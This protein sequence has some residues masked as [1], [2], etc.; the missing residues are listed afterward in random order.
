MCGSS[1]FIY[2]SGPVHIFKRPRCPRPRRYWTRLEFFTPGISNAICAM[3]ALV[4]VIVLLLASHVNSSPIINFS[5]DTPRHFCGSQ[6]ANVLA[7]ICSH[8]YNFHPVNDDVTPPSRRRKR[9][10]IVEECCENTCTPHHLKAYCW[11][12]QRADKSAFGTSLEKPSVEIFSIP[13][14]PP[15]RQ[16]Q[17]VDNSLLVDQTT[18]KT[19]SNS[20]I[21]NS[22]ENNRKTNNKHNSTPHPPLYI[23][24]LQANHDISQDRPYVQCNRSKNT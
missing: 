20:I 10:P 3:N 15:V 7:L 2:G 14:I 9:V 11:E 17:E 21:P 5:W 1:Q 12:N 8:G 4:M 23:K 22:K 19:K 24:V 13:Q 6:L 16:K 18:I